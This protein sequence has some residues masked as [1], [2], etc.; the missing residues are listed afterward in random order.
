MNQSHVLIHKSVAEA[1]P[2]TNSKMRESGG[3]LRNF[4]A[5]DGGTGT[6]VGPRNPVT[7]FFNDRSRQ[8]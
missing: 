8:S 1:K 4:R 6:S 2:I 7:T 5:S 3:S